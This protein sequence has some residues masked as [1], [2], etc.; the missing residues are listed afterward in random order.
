[1]SDIPDDNLFNKGLTKTEFRFHNDTGFMSSLHMES[2][3][4]SILSPE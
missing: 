2:L 4:L 3:C 1:M